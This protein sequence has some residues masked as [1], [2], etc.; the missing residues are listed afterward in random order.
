MQNKKCECNCDSC[1]SVNCLCGKCEDN[2]CGNCADNSNK[3]SCKRCHYNDD[4]SNND[5]DQE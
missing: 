3:C 4:T 2:Q 1:S 5:N